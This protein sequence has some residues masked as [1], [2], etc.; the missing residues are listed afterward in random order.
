MLV[1]LGKAEQV[2]PGQGVSFKVNGRAIAVFNVKGE[3]Y[4]VDDCCSHMGAPL[5]GGMLA[6]K[7]ITCEWHG[8]CFDLENGSALEGPCRGDIQAYKIVV[9][10]DELEVEV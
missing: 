7:S 3:Y 8:A 4:A 5:A 10:N 2:K 9:K 6:G 1:N